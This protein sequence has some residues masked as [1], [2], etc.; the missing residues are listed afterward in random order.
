MRIFVGLTAAFALFCLTAVHAGQAKPAAG[1]KPAAAAAAAASPESIT[2]G[3]A[4]YK[5]Q[6][7]MCHGVAGL[8]DGPAAK[9]LKGKLPSL[10]DKAVMSK[11]HG[12]A[13]SRG[14]YGREE[15]R[16][17]EHAGAGKAPQ[18]RRDHRYRE[19]REDAGEVGFG[20]GS[21]L[22]ALRPER[23]YKQKKGAGFQRPFLFSIPCS[24]FL[25]PF[26]FFLFPFPLPLPTPAPSRGDGQRPRSSPP[27][28]AIRRGRA[29]RS[30][31]RQNSPSAFRERNPLSTSC[32][33]TSTQI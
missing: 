12:R 4:L 28:F 9:N 33:R 1:Q 15:D 31:A 29:A 20:L 11:L 32:D 6:C 22:L 16:N 25:L 23:G 26:S 5:R 19:L 2:N 3:A 30:E 10:A 8:G 18:T 21:R 27:A 13:H 14:D 17:R 24:L 7:V